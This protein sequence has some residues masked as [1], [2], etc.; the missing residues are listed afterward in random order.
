MNEVRNLIIIGSGPSSYTA[1]RYP[2]RG[3]ECQV[4]AVVTSELDDNYRWIECEDRG[5]WTSM[6]GSR[7]CG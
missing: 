5:L 3:W 4:K 7:V 1:A 6:T 2:A